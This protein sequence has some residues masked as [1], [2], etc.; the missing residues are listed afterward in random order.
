MVKLILQFTLLVC[1]ELAVFAGSSIDEMLGAYGNGNYSKALKLAERLPGKPEAKLVSALCMIF[2]SLK[3]DM[4]GGMLELEKLYQNKNLPLP[5][6]A[7]AALIYG[8]VAQLVQERKELYGD[9]ASGVNAHEVFQ[10]VID[11]TPDSREACTAL[12]FDLTKELDHSGH[13]KLDA[14]FGRLENFCRDFKGKPE[15]LTPLHLLADQKYIALKK[16]Y[17][18]AVRHLEKAYELG[19][20]NPRDAEIVLYRIGRIY[21]LRLNNKHEAMKY[22]NEF[23]RKYPDSGYAPNVK[24]FLKQ[25]AGQ[26]KRD[27]HG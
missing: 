18:V 2:D 17:A 7:R 10:S 16:D 5:V 14:T 27:N 13:K 20:V 9:F 1:F 6:W 15:Y 4:S 24:R 11:R 23:L 25:L 3:Q 26:E 21:D 19:I 12:F 8:R 22:Y